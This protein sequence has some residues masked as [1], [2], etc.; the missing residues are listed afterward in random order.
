MTRCDS[1]GTLIFESDIA[2]GAVKAIPD[3]PET[4][5]LCIKCNCEDYHVNLSIPASKQSTNKRMS[6]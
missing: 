5:N 6:E 4:D 1:C 2:R 3:Q